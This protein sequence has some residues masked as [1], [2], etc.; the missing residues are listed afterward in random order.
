[1]QVE[2]GIIQTQDFS[3][4]VEAQLRLSKRVISVIALSL[5]YEVSKLHLSASVRYEGDEA[6]R[7]TTKGQ[8]GSLRTMCGSAAA[9]ATKDYN[10][11]QRALAFFCAAAALPELL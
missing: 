9:P 4:I 3:A 7:G 8:S 10:S 6:S 11:L 2:R 5:T 1:M